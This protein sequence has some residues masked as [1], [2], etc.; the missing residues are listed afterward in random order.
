MAVLPPDGVVRAA[1]RWLS[2]LDRSTVVQ[3]AA[4]IRADVAYTDL[5]PTQYSTAFEWLRGIGLLEE[6]PHGT[7]L[8][9]GVRGLPGIQARQ[10]LFQRALEVASPAWLRDADLLI[11]DATE[12]PQDAMSLAESLR[13]D[14]GT[15]LLAIRQVHG[16]IDLEARAR[17]GLAGER[18]LLDYLENLWPGSTRHVALESDGFGYDVVLNVDGGP[19]HLEVKTTTRR[20]RLIVYVSRHEYEVSRVDPAWRLVLVGLDQN[21]NMTTLGTVDFELVYGRLPRD[22][23]SGARWESVRIELRQDELR[24]GLD[25]P[26]GLQHRKHSSATADAAWTASHVEWLSPISA[27]ERGG[28]PLSQLG[29][30]R[31]GKGQGH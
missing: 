28:G 6:G 21:D 10:V 23:A 8:H 5:S 20:G 22:V 13:I 18:A 24:A 9:S 7:T 16:K 12:L 17:V 29:D 15:A 2:L 19:W 14:S 31:Q 4:L 27:A 11:P 3:A 25:L 26:G 1:E 30:S